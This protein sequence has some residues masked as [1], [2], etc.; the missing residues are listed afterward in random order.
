MTHETVL[1]GPL[2][3]DFTRRGATRWSQPG[4]AVWHGGLALAMSA[5][6]ADTV[7]SICATAG[8]WARRWGWPGLAGAGVALGGVD[9]PDD[10]VFRNHYEG[11][12]RRQT[13]LSSSSPLPLSLLEGCTAAAVLSPLMPSDVPVEAAAAALRQRGAFVAADVQ[14]LLRVRAPGG[15]IEARPADLKGTL[16]NVQALKFSQREFRIYAGLPDSPGASHDWEVAVV[17]VANQLDAEIVVSR[18]SAGAALAL[19]G[20]PTVVRAPTP[21][22]RT[23]ADLTGAGDILI[24]TYARARSIGV[25]PAAALER[26]VRETAAVLSARASVG[27]GGSELLRSIRRLQ[28]AAA[29]VRRRQRRGEGREESFSPEGELARRVT[30]ALPSLP[31]SGGAASRGEALVSGCWALFSVGWPG[32]HLAA[33]TLESLATAEMSRL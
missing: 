4:G 11:E 19:P 15:R 24:A 27:A 1:V 2:T 23:N 12:K 21:P 33:A 9:T 28:L 18:G 25:E 7:V 22:L 13:L 17:A 32:D 6:V 30:A 16:P 10:T 20:S 29:L 14:G 31:L 3:R 5:P 8:P 26:A